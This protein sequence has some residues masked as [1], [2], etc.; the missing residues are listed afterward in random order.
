MIGGPT[1]FAGSE[2]Y[3]YSANTQEG[4]AIE[5]AKKL[6]ASGVDRI[7]LGL[8]DGSIGQLAKPFPDGAPP[9]KDLWEKE[10]GIKVDIVGVPNGQEFTKVMQDI[11][12]KA[13]SFD[14][15]A[16]EWNRLGDLAETGGILKLDDFVAK[17]KPEWD[18]P[19]R[20]YVGGAKGVALLNQYRGSTYGVCLDGDFQTWV[21]RTDLFNDPVEQ[22]AFKT[23]TDTTSRRRRPGSSSTRSR[24]SFIAG[25]EH[26]RLN[27]HPQSG[28]GLHQLVPALHLD[29]FAEPV[30]VRRRRKPAD[31]LRPWRGRHEG[32]CRLTG[33]QV[34]GRDFVGLARAVR[35]LRQGRRSVDLRL[36]EPA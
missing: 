35:Q 4:R 19:E 16:V 10:T 29:G 14:I 21:Y 32:I 26:A 27:R 6:K 34:S 11:S 8:S 17:Y 2:R 25:Q 1:G 22:K 15:Y 36:L 12:T 5:A 9:I 7:V 20:G 18:D 3:Q 13:G 33:L 28:V 24:C 31:Q 23:N 30:P